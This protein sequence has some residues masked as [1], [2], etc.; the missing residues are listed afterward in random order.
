V[1]PALFLLAKMIQPE[2]KTIGKKIKMG[3]CFDRN[4]QRLVYTLVS[5]TELNGFEAGDLIKV[6]GWSKGKGFTGVMKRWGFAGGPRTHGQSDRER[7]PGSIG[8]GTTPGRVHK[9]KKMAGRTGN[10]RT[11]IKNL[12]L[13]DI[14]EK[15]KTFLIKGLL[16][17]GRNASLIVF[18]AGKVKNFTPLL[19]EEEV[20][21]FTPDAQAQIKEETSESEGE[22]SS[23]ENKKEVGN[24][25]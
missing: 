19:K 5:V 8:Q 3:Q 20:L 17:G 23:H 10:Q 21:A 22:A 4:G 13:L 6:A 11:T 2:I 15:D 16:P 14:N 25:N 18:K 7:A 1:P 9:G 12:T 24:G